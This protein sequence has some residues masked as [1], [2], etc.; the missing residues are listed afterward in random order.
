MTLRTRFLVVAVVLVAALTAATVALVRGAVTALLRGEL[1]KRAASIAL[2]AAERAAEP[3]LTENQLELRLALLA[4]TEHEADVA[5]AYFVGAQGQ[6]IAHSFGDGF[7]RSLVGRPPPADGVERLQT[8]RGG[9]IHA[10]APIL[11]GDLGTAHVGLSEASLQATL[12]GV[13]RTLLGIAAA[14]ILGG[15]ALAA[16]A[17]EALTRPLL[18]LTAAAEAAGDGDL[19]RTVETRSGGEVA[20]LAQA[21]NRALARIGDA[22]ARLIGANE[23]LAAEIEERKRAE[24]V[25]LDLQAQLLQAQKLESIGRLVGGVAHDF[26]NILCAVLAS[27]D[28]ALRRL[29]ANHP[30]TE[31]VAVMVR[32]SE[33]AARLTQQLLAYGQR[34]VLQR[35]PT[36]LVTLVRRTA[37]LLRE[38]LGN[39]VLLEVASGPG[40]PLVLADPGQIEQVVMNLAV[41]ARDAMPGGGLLELRTAARD[42]PPPGLAGSEPLAPG[43]YATITVTDTGHGMAPEVQER[44]FDPFFTTKEI[45]KGTGL[46]LPTAVGIVRQHGGRI[47]VESEPGRGSRFRVLLPAAPQDEEERRGA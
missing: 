47:E 13:V 45:G 10:A 21:F 14:V 25:N 22:Q 6:V 23:A 15:I 9:V 20:R 2:H 4:L 46:G 33:R 42:V 44:I 16:A 36:D 26:N 35:R 30:A 32:E 43:R 5:Y 3:L 37:D 41:N 12:A 29:P 17:A 40:V 38:A 28:L 31:K 24:A 39:D 8:D 11:G 27:G 7:P 19:G 18:A 34:Q 1:E